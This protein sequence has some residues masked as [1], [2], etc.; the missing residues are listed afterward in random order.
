[1]V[2]FRQWCHLEE[3]SYTIRKTAGRREKN[4]DI[5]HGATIRLEITSEGMEVPLES[6]LLLSTTP[7][8]NTHSILYC[9][10]RDTTSAGM[11]L[12]NSRDIGWGIQRLGWVLFVLMGGSGWICW[13]P[14]LMLC[15]LVANPLGSPIWY[16]DWTLCL[17]KT[18]KPLKITL[19]CQAT[20]GTILFE[21]ATFKAREEHNGP[22]LLKD[23][24]TVDVI[25]G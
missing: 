19:E 15:S 7:N 14:C 18:K 17:G 16:K 25:K 12:W 5:A 21:V 23:C 24:H 1:M 22:L 11:A 8:I 20:F 10:L 4:C 2:Q 3:V 13:W 9:A 6:N